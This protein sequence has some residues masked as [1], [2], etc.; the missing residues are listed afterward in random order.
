MKIS[1][2]LLILILLCFQACQQNTV[3][4]EAY[5]QLGSEPENRA[6]S[7]EFQESASGSVNLKIECQKYSRGTITFSDQSGFD[8]IIPVFIYPFDLNRKIYPHE[9]TPAKEHD[10]T[11]DWDIANARLKVLL[12][13]NLQTIRLSENKDILTIDRISIQNTSDRPDSSGVK[14]RFTG[15]DIAG[16]KFT[17]E[18]T[19][20]IAFGNSTTAFRRSISGVYAQRLPDILY[21]AG[22]ANIVYNEGIPGSHT[23]SLSDNSRHN[24]PHGLDRFDRSVLSRNPDV[25]IISFGL[26]DSWVDT[27]KEESRIALADYEANLSQMVNKLQDM[28]VFT[29]LMTPNALGK[30]Y[31]K[32]R[33]KITSGYADIV[34]SLAE[35]KSIALVDQWKLFEEYASDGGQEI[36]DLLLDGLHPN[37]IWHER[38]STILANIIVEYYNTKPNV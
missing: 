38:L 24:V 31:E 11:L 29:I 4:P 10:I 26:N 36:D 12:D 9:P 20:I 16:N 13:S 19:C 1:D 30:K 35:E 3:F 28:N 2:P 25:V 32:W 7:F 15:S 17:D 14:I 23:G 22:I 18:R 6:I 8:S 33:Y 5:Q 27:G 34:R 37:D 21:D